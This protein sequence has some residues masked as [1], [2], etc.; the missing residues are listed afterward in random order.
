MI[1]AGIGL[2]FIVHQFHCNPVVI[3]SVIGSV[4]GAIGILCGF[5]GSLTTPMAA[6]FNIVRAALLELKDHN[7]VIKS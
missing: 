7:G 5:C 2:P 6:S 1:T 4:I 3:G